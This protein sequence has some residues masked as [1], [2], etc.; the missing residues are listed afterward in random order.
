MRIRGAAC[1]VAIAF[2]AAAGSAR[3]DR[4]QSFTGNTTNGPTF[5]RP[6]EAGVLSA[7]NPRHR[8]QRFRLLSNAECTLYSAQQ[9]DGFLHLYRSPFN[10]ASPLTNLIESDDDAELIVGTSRIPRDLDQ[11]AISLTAGVYVLVNSGFGSDSQGSFQN[12]IQCDVDVQPFHGACGASFVGILQEQ[13]VCLQ[14]RFVVAIDQ[15]TNHATDGIGTPVRFGST[16]SS[17]FWFYNDRNFEVLLKVLN[18]CLIN[19]RWWVFFAGTTN[20]GFRVRVAD[21][22]TLQ[23]K[24]YFRPLGPTSLTETDTSAFATCP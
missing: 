4:F 15:I 10:P 16:D 14:D 19:N 2:V 12:F 13:Q 8:A 18:G 3:A 9:Y 7:H 23:V 20:Q 11:D 22:N 17:F 21:S 24:T 5:N 6:T 1:F